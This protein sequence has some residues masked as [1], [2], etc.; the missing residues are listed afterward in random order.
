MPSSYKIY[1]GLR[2]RIL[3]DAYR[4]HLPDEV[5]DRPKQGFEVPIGELLRGPLRDL[6]HDTV[7]KETVESFG[8]LSFPAVATIYSDHEHRRADH[9]DLLWAVLSL[10]WWQARCS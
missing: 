8:L 1:R 7:R 10:C 6:F 3:V 9:A 4:G 2:K 5:L